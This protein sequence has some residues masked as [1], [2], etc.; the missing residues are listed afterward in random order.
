MVVPR[1]NIHIVYL[2]IYSFFSKIFIEQ[3]IHA[4]I[5]L[6][7]IVK[8]NIIFYRKLVGSPVYIYVSLTIWWCLLKESLNIFISFLILQGG[9]GVIK[10]FFFF[11]GPEYHWSYTWGFSLK[12]YKFL[13]LSL[14]YFR[15][16]ISFLT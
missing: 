10:L 14:P 1:S 12:Y 16:H 13:F 5:P 11:Y 2:V 7:D 4:R 3:L 6:P 8:S 9:F 15:A